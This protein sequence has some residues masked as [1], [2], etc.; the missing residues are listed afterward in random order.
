MDK[1]NDLNPSQEF[2]LKSF[3]EILLI[4]KAMGN[5]SR[6][7]ILILLVNRPLNFQTLLD[8]MNLK[9]SALANHL[10]QLK[11][12]GLVEKI[13][14]GTYGITEDGKRYIFFIEKSFKDSKKVKIKRKEIRQ[15]KN[16]AKSFLERK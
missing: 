3:D 9:K 8:E 5:S 12:L 14:H 2:L 10:T 15:R 16:L 11:N 6:L 1:K 7:K 4:L 13:Q